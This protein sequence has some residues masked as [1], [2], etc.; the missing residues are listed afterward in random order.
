M[1]TIVSGPLNQTKTT[2]HAPIVG[3]TRSTFTDIGLKS[4]LLLDIAHHSCE[5]I[6]TTNP[7]L[8]QEFECCFLIVIAVSTDNNRSRR[9]IIHHKTLLSEIH[10][11]KDN[12]RTTSQDLV[13]MK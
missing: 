10:R 2:T 1:V 3:N 13:L 9:M 4:T 7:T 11:R 5:G 8:L 12:I 6:N